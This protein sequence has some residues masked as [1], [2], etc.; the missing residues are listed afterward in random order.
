MNE[1][2]GSFEML[3]FGGGMQG[4]EEWAGED[5]ADGEMEEERGRPAGRAMGGGRGMGRGP[6]RG[7]LGRRLPLQTGQ[8][9]QGSGGTRP[10]PGRPPYP[11]PPRGPYWGPVVGGWP[12]GV[13]VS[14]PGPY[15]VAAPAHDDPWR[16]PPGQDSTFEPVD[17]PSQGGDDNGADELQGEVQQEIP[18]KV[19]EAIASLTVKLNFEDAGTLA[20]VR[21]AGKLTGAAIYIIAFRKNGQQRAYVGETKD[22]QNRIR[23]HMLCG[24]VLGVPLRNYRIYVAQPKVD[25]ATRRQLEKDI[26]TYMRRP[27]NAGVVTNQRSELEME[28]MGP[29][30][31]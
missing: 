31:T 16:T 8:T 2:Y 9:G 27:E 1:Q 11:R 15:V 18:A 3:E 17:F 10:R 22:I 21:K 20:A 19:K 24:A 13:M 12:Y 14:D 28:V 4:E 30:W 25:P 29:D 23:K 26:N 6:A 7:G 5:E